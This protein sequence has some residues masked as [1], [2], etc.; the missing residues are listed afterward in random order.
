MQN[1]VW[2]R[3]ILRDRVFSVYLPDLFSKILEKLKYVVQISHGNSLLST[4]IWENAF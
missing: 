2:P 3:E 1:F 4:F